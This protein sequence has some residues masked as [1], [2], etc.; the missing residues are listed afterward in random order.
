MVIGKEVL[1]GEDEAA[2]RVREMLARETCRRVPLVYLKNYDILIKQSIDYEP[3][4]SNSK[5]VGRN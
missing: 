1:E 4:F 3:V 5:K 2:G